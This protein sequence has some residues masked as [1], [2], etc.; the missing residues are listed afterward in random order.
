MYS[1]MVD[2]IVT[3]IDL[4]SVP[5]DDHAFCRGHAVFDT[6]SFTKGHVYR[7]DVHLDR[8]FK[9]ARSAQI[10]LPFEGSEAQ[11]REKMKQVI[12]ATCIASGRRGASVRYWLSAGYGNLGFTTQGCTP[13]FF[14]LVFGPVG[15]AP[16]RGSEVTVRSVPLKP[17]LLAEMKSNN[18]MLNCLVGMAAQDAGGFFG[19]MVRPD[20]IIAEGCIVNVMF[21]GEDKVLRT[22][23]FEGILAG[24]T[25]KKAMELANKHLVKKGTGGLLT[26]V[27]Q[28][29]ISLE[30]A[31]TC[32]E[33]FLVGGDTH[34]Y[35]VTVWDGQKVGIGHVGPVAKEIQALLLADEEHGQGEHIKLIYPTPDSKL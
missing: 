31:K 21:V 32:V 17:P 35:P 28:E 8:F 6:C 12:C 19:I 11:N 5:I 9:S 29:D 4:M 33:V 18:Y 13:T 26:A 14:C 15:P 27:R 2:G 22:P 3:D 7:L 30:E 34:L 23:K 25:A 10:P 24:T 16:H 20:G 1:S